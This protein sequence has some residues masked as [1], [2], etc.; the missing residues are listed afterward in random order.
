MSRLPIAPSRHNG[1]ATRTDAPML[2]APARSTQTR[3]LK[4]MREGLAI[5]FAILAIS[6]V[7]LPKNT[8][9]EIHQLFHQLEAGWNQ[10]VTD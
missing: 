4:T 10:P 5:A 2:T 8:A 9:H 7:F 3:R 1:G 6:I